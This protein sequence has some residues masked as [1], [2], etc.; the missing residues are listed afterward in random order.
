MREIVS[1]MQFLLVQS[2]EQLGA[3]IESVKSVNGCTFHSR[4]QRHVFI[5]CFKSI[6]NCDNK[7]RWINHS[8]SLSLRLSAS[9]VRIYRDSSG[10]KILSWCFQG[11]KTG[12]P[13][14]VYATLLTVK[15]TKFIGFWYPH[16]T[17]F[18]GSMSL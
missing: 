18:D 6:G 17:S 10:Q 1:L 16:P 14:P 15:V 5:K 3:D 13:K 7:Y 9:L 12:V 4:T 2:I 8:L 11:K